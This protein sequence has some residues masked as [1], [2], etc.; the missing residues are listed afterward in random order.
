MAPM[1]TPSLTAAGRAT[2]ASLAAA[3]AP[4][5]DARYAAI[6]RRDRAADGRFWYGVVTTGV[7][8]RPS[9]AA[10]LAKREN[11]RFFASREDARDAGLRA[12]KR[13]RPDADS[14]R[15]HLLAATERACRLIE[16]AEEPP[17]LAELA[18]AAGLSRY[19]FHRVF[20]DIVG[21]TPKQYAQGRRRARLQDELVAGAPVTEAIYAAGF[22]SST[23]FYEN[24]AGILGMHASAYRRGGRDMAIRYAAV[25]CSLGWVLVAAT[26]RGLCSIALGDSAQE[27]AAGL[28]ARFP[29]ATIAPGGDDFAALVARVVDLI[30]APH[31]A[32]ELPLDIRGTSFQQR[33]WHALRQIPAGRTATYGEVAA[34]LG[35][36]RA[37]RAV[38]QACAANPLAVAIP[39]HRV[40][41]ADGDLAGYR[42]GKARK[43]A[44]LAR[45][46]EAAGR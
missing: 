44:L 8:C 22:G 2:Q 36:P 1:P 20:K 26:D 16:A 24:A 15:A 35:A 41:A 40:L 27:L 7:Y 31:G 10:R 33:V 38:A 37:V 5:D 21:V 3:S 9:C 34:R 28:A 11:V 6:A 13:C 23:R 12:C 17:T 4:A 14:D 29:S 39:C 18:D 25:P 30:E 46:A 19:H 45:E 32:V 43:R 42:W